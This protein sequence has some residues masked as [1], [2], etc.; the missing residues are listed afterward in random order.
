MPPQAF[1]LRPGPARQT[2]IQV[3]KRWGKR[4]LVVPTGVGDPTPN[5]GIEHTSQVV[6]LLVNA[7][8]KAPASDGLTD[9]FCCAVAD[10][11]TEIDEVLP[12]PILRPPGANGRAQEVEVLG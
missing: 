11:W 2:L 1:I 5:D 4:R 9:G 12:P 6:H 7:T 10:A 8:S 3:A